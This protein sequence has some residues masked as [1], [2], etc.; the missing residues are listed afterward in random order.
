MS[1][2]RAGTED[3]S[4]SSS[5]LFS[6]PYLPGP[7]YFDLWPSRVSTPPAQEKT[8]ISSWILLISEPLKNQKVLMVE[9]IDL[10]SYTSVIDGFKGGMCVVDW[11]HEF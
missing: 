11:N 9:S 6:Y 3:D 7:S 8:L 2:S 4:P 1:C 10:G 5:F